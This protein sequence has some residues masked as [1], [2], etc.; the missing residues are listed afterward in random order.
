MKLTELLNKSDISIELSE[1]YNHIIEVE[2]LSSRYG[3][4]KCIL[5]QYDKNDK[6]FKLPKTFYEDGYNKVI[7]T[8]G[9]HGNIILYVF[10][11]GKDARK[12][13]FDF[14]YLQLETF[15][16]YNQIEYT[17]FSGE[18]AHQM[19]SKGKIMKLDGYLYCVK[20]GIFYIKS[21]GGQDE[22]RKAK[23][24]HLNRRDWVELR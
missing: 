3:Y 16:A 6:T 1:S 15:V 8:V 21:S 2:E 7:T 11:R 23:K 12:F 19:M 5:T 14:N 13:I 24:N 20:D 9:K 22:W 10:K 18:V 4:G 17:T